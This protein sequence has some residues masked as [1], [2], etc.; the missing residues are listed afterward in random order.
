[1]MEKSDAEILFPARK[2]ARQEFLVVAS[3]AIPAAY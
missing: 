1:M 2:P 3:F